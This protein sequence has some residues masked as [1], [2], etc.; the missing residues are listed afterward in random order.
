[1][2]E[3]RMSIH[4]RALAV[5]AVAVG[6]F[7][8]IEASGESHMCAQPL[9]RAQAALRDSPSPMGFRTTNP[10]LASDLDLAA[11]NGAALCPMPKAASREAQR[12]LERTVTPTRAVVLN[13]NASH[14]IAIAE[15]TPSDER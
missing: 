5:G 11:A 7:A 1:M 3:A 8:A 13:R 4:W 15:A 6:C 14:A 12:T 9:Q 2:S 10:D